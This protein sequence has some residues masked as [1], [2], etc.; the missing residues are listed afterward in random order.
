MNLLVVAATGFEINPFI[1]NNRT[2]DVLI[3]GIGIPATIFQLTKH[4]AQQKY[5][6]VIQAGIAGSFNN[7]LVAGSVAMI[8][9]DT[10]GDIGIEEKGKFS[11][12]FETGLAY[13]NDFPFSNGWLLNEHEYFTRPFLPVARAITVNKIIDDEIQIKRT[14]EK[15]GADIESMEGAAFHYVC[16]REKIKFL[17][18]RAI[19]NITGERD[20]TKW[21][22]KEAIANLNIELVQL[23]KKIM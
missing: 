11:T 14:R 18:L 1:E 3:A 21:T 5:D 7:T 8:E 22:M 17:Q 23:V 4:L 12:L 20:K 19:S 16:L 6:L 9:A 2:A 10:F 15:F 13:E